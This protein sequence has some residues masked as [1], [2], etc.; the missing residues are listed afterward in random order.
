MLFR[1]INTKILNFPGALRS[2]NHVF[3]GLGRA[4]IK[5]SRKK[6]TTRPAFRAHWVDSR[7]L[8]LMSFMILKF[9][10]G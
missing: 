6:T 3:K 9:V 10:I 2:I 1:A 4:E 7:E 5:N 8:D